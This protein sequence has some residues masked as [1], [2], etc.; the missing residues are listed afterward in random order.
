M[1]RF[2]LTRMNAQTGHIIAIPPEP[3]APTPMDPFH[4]IVIGAFQEM[5]SRAATLMNARKAPTTVHRAAR[6]H[7][8]MSLDPF[9]APAI[10]GIRAV[11]RPVL[12]LMNAQAVPTIVPVLEALVSTRRGRLCV[13]VPLD[14]REQ[15]ALMSTNALKA[16]TLAPVQEEL[17]SIQLDLFRAHARRATRERPVS[18]TMN[19]RLARTLAQAREGHV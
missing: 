9:L 6:R 7:A 13:C 15:D 18:I 12:T 1:E 3:L 11:A 10:S 4:V 19:A 8:P 5:A 14:S 16:R 17:A 2:A